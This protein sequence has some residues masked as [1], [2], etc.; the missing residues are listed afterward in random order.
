MY[1]MLRHTVLEVD[2]ECSNRVPPVVGNGMSDIR[3]SL[4]HIDMK[5]DHHLVLARRIKDL[6][7]VIL[8]RIVRRQQLAVEDSLVH[9]SSFRGI[10]LSVL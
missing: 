2:K 4:Q 7:V 10:L 8:D 9:L 6:L 5:D 3:L 1:L